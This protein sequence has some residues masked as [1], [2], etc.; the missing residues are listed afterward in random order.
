MMAVQL[1]N[2]LSGAT[3]EV[4]NTND[5]PTGGISIVGTASQENELTVEV[6]ALE[7]QDGLGDLSY[8]WLRNG[9]EISGATSDNL[10]AD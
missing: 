9:S 6:S 8:Q 7:D 5:N 3:T 4:A 10:H 2:V 1:K